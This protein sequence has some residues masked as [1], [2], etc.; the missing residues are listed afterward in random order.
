MRR[1]DERIL[2]THTGSLPRPTGAALPGTPG[3]GHGPVD[4]EVLG[5]A[6]DETV[7]AQVDAGI[8]V[9]NDGEMSKPS[10]STYVV[11]RLTGFEH[12]VTEARRLP[13]SEEFPEYFAR[14]GDQLA[15]AMTNPVCVGP[16]AYRGHGAVETDIA[17]LQA[18]GA[19][20]GAGELFMTAASPGVIAQFMV[21]RHYG[22]HDDYVDALASAMREEY[23]AIAS[24]GI[25]LQLDCPDLA[26]WPVYEARGLS[27]TEF[28]DMVSRHVE[29]INAATATIDPDAMRL[30]VC[31]GNYEGP[32]NHDIALVEIVERILPA[33]PAALVLEAA[34]PRHEHEWAV[35][36]DVELPEGKVL[37][38]GVLDTTTNYVEHPELVA[39]RLERLARL[40]GMERVIAGTDCGFATFATALAVDPRIVWAK[41]ASLVQGAAIA[42]S[43]LAAG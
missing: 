37:V 1:S 23:E 29:A 17:N 4:P 26:S 10:Y 11:D 33:R 19:K 36:K 40:V 20:A 8:D 38:P 30:H 7:S 27:K 16:V 21:D 6:V 28:L 5:A 12:A 24:A 9:V 42:T 2:T 35:F 41:L 43:R 31:W 34:N 32:H 18:A 3:L 15:R 14:F 39:E 25:V 22:S 13:W